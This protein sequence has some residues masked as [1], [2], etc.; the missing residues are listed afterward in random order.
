MQ[1]ALSAYLAASTLLHFASQ[2][3]QKS[4]QVADSVVS[5]SSVF[6]HIGAPPPPPAP[7]PP[8]PP[9][10]APPPPAPAPPAPPPPEPALP[11]APAPPV[12]APAPPVDA[13][14]PPVDAPAPP[15]DAPAPPVDAP[16]V[17][18]PVPP[19]P[20]SA[21]SSPQAASEN[22]S[23]AIVPT[24]KTRPS[25]FRFFILFVPLGKRRE[26]IREDAATVKVM[27]KNGL[28]RLSPIRRSELPPPGLGAL[29]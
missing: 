20:P 17:A 15:V 13:P 2:S 16:A 27:T 4:L 8:A 1:A 10:P 28:N 5:G 23:A 22:D 26:S 21:A 29:A 18:P 11:P 19:A 12:D 7:P 3:S 6:A 9:P 24:P 25:L 14:A